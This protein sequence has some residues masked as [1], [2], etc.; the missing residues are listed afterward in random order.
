MNND[1]TIFSQLI[2]LAP[3]YEFD[4]CVKRYCTDYNPRKFLFW[5]QFLAMAFAQLTLRESLRDIEICLSSLGSKIY[6]M[7]FRNKVTKST[8]ADANNQRDWRVWSDFAQVLIKQARLLYGEEDLA[9]QFKNA[10]YVLDSTTISLCLTLFPWARYKTKERAI[11]VH[12]QL[13]LRGNIPSFILISQGRIADVNFLDDLVLEAGAMYVMDR[14]YLDF[15]R[16]FNFTSNGAFFVTR[17][18]NNMHD[19]RIQIFSRCHHGA[20]RC[21]AAIRPLTRKSKKAYPQKLRLVE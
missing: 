10:M 20:I 2:D 13:D 3:R 16:L 9:V 1:R 8:L 17:L 5:N 21:D 15:T 14:A 18:K 7:G 11:K 4:L 19:R 6:H 12:T